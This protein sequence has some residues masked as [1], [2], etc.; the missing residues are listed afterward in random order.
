MACMGMYHLERALQEEAE[1]FDLGRFGILSDFALDVACGAAIVV[2]KSEYDSSE[3]IQSAMKEFCEK[4]QYFNADGKAVPFG[5]ECEEFHE[6]P[7]STE[8]FHDSYT[9]KDYVV[10]W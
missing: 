9:D 7:Y 6:T 2:L 10:I 1:K 8:V 3:A 5:K 4:A